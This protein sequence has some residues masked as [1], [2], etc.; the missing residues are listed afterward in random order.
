MQEPEKRKRGDGSIFQA[1][2]STWWI[3][4]S[5]R[6]IRHRENSRSTD[7]HVAERLLK[8]RLAELETQ[9]FIPRASVRVDELVSDL[10]AEYREKQQKSLASVEQRWRL[11]LSPFFTKRRA[12][13]ITTDM[14][15]RY[16][17]QRQAEGASPATCNRE[18]AILKASFNLALESTPPKVMRTPFIPMFAEKNVR[19]GFLA[20][21][22][23]A[24][25]AR[26]CAAKGLWLRTAFAIGCT[27]G[28][29]LSEVLGLRVRQV[30]LADRTVRLEVGSTKNGRGRIVSLTEECYT[31]LQACCTGKKSDDYVL[32]R[33]KNKPVKDFRGAWQYAVV[34][35]G[36]GH[37]LC[38]KCQREQTMKHRCKCGNRFRWK[39]VGLLFHDLRR[40][41]VRNLRRLGVAESVAMKI[42][43]HKTASVFRRYDIIEQADLAAAARLLDAK[44]KSNGTLVGPE[45][46]EF[47]QSCTKS[48]AVATSRQK[49]AVLPN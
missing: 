27:F 36:L 16:I 18:C 48:N 23:Q 11:H 33:G 6:G 2:S 30:D 1:G 47:S 49:A 31:L 21:A 3:S 34:R 35:A 15:R 32:T 24:K 19:T 20:D 25:L 45:V 7:Y 41:A 10:M 12:S 8:R 5:E 14:V 38:R 37:F 13:D 46:S 28:W 22:D 9:T 42:S 44:Q 40:T 43:G 29:R 39:F 26:E 17:A 4:F